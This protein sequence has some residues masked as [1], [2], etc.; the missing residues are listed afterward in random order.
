MEYK[1]RGSST[2]E[3]W[4]CNQ[5][6]RG[7]FSLELR[8]ESLESVLKLRVEKKNSVSLYLCVD[9]KLLKKADRIE[10]P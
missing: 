3:V 6:Y 8:V 7:L 9:I 5:R 4:R 2:S 10:M 1:H